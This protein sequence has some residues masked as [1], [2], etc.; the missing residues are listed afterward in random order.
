MAPSFLL[1]DTRYADNICI[2]AY[3]S[4]ATTRVRDAREAFI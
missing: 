1:L 2:Y 4:A 3:F